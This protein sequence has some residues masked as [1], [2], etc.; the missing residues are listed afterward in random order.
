MNYNDV[1]G[2]LYIMYK[3]MTFKEAMEQCENICK[4]D[5]IEP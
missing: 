4:C 2:G 1:E 3:K 5:K